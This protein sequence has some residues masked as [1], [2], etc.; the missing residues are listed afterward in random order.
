MTGAVVAYFRFD[1]RRRAIVATPAV[2][3]ASATPAAATLAMRLARR[4][5]RSRPVTLSAILRATVV[6]LAPA[7][8]AVFPARVSAFRAVLA[9]FTIGQPP[10]SA[11]A[12]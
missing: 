10:N 1:C 11:C 8:R 6:A 12:A 7:F 9:V 4:F 2:T 5:F 3:A